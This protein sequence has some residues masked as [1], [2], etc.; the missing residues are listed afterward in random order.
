MVDFGVVRNL[1]MV[2]VAVVLGEGLGGVGAVGTVPAAGIGGA[3]RVLPALALTPRH[4]FHKG[5]EGQCAG[6][7][8]QEVE[9][10]GTGPVGVAPAPVTVDGGWERPRSRS[11]WGATG[12]SKED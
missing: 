11:S 9:M 12:G 10:G 3:A 5:G 8:V 1:F 4:A 2:L 7:A 6:V